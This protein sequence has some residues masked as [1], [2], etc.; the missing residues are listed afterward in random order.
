[1]SLYKVLWS[2][3]DVWLL[4]TSARVIILIRG[5]T[6]GIKHGGFMGEKKERKTDNER[7]GH[8]SVK[9][10]QKRNTEQS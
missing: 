6:I 8:K 4:A 7:G 10:N 1:M 2:Y 3:K 9:E 5:H